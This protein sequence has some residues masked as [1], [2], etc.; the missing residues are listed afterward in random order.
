MK[1]NVFLVEVWWETK[2]GNPTSTRARVEADDHEAA[3]SYLRDRVT[4]YKRCGK[5]HACNGYVWGSVEG[6][7][8]VF[9]RNNGGER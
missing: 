4:Q 2:L 6:N 9:V 8:V 7:V 3:I 5:I 1:S